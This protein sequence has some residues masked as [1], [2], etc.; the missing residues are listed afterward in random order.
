MCPTCDDTGWD[1]RDADHL[2]RFATTP[3]PCP[4]NHPMDNTIGAI[5]TAAIEFWETTDS[6]PLHDLIPEQ[7][8]KW[9]MLCDAIVASRKEAWQAGDIKARLAEEIHAVSTWCEFGPESCAEHCDGS[10][11]E[12]AAFVVTTVAFNDDDE[13]SE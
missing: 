11:R 13:G 7:G 6:A 12:I 8:S 2:G 9:D 5:E 1:L 3:A 4:E 10:C